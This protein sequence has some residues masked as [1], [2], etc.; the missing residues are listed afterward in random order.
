MNVQENFQEILNEILEIE[1]VLQVHAMEGD[2]E[3]GKCVRKEARYLDIFDILKALRSLSAV[4][5]ADLFK[6]KDVKNVFLNMGGVNLNIYFFNKDFYM[7][8]VSDEKANLGKIRL[9]V[10]KYQESLG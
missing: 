8:V 7:A 5:A 4:K 9:V 2:N 3:L 1:G 6:K 10:R